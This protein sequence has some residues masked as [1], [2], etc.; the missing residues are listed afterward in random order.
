MNGGGI[1]ALAGA[2]AN[3]RGPKRAAL[4]YF[5]QREKVACFVDVNFMGHSTDPLGSLL[6]R[7]SR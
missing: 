1:T 5:F 3:P 6:S 4:N 2:R 7:V